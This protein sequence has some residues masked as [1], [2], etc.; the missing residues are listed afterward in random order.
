[1]AA[2][3]LLALPLAVTLAACPGGDGTTG[4]R[5]TSD[6]VTGSFSGAALGSASVGDLAIKGG[7]VPEPPSPDVASAYFT[8]T[9]TGSVAET[10]TAVS[11][12]AA[13]TVVPMTET[14]SGSTGSMADLAQVTIPAHGSMSFTPNRAHLMLEQPRALT[15]GDHVALSLTFSHAGSVQVSLPV[16]PFTGSTDGTSSGSGGDMGDMPGM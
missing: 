8:I 12:D 2:A 3:G 13:P 4:G 7:Y 11:S 15:V 16:L 1:L 14:T 9:N 6:M 10:L 5:F